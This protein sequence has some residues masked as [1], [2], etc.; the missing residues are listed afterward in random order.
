MTRNRC[1]G[2]LQTME[3][4]ILFKKI[5]REIFLPFMFQVWGTFTPESHALTVIT[6]YSTFFERTLMF[7]RRV[8]LIQYNYRVILKSFFL[9][10]KLQQSL[11]VKQ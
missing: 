5:S 7:F 4:K 6:D 8:H 2:S 1:R 11:H 10:N 3:N 9:I